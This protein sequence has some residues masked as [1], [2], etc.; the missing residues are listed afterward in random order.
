MDSSRPKTNDKEKCQFMISEYKINVM[1]RFKLDVNFV[2]SL[3]FHLKIF[4]QV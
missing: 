4:S 1:L 2:H 3:K